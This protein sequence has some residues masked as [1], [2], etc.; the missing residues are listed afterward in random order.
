MSE[1][2]TLWPCVRH[3][4]QSPDC[5]LIDSCTFTLANVTAA[6]KQILNSVTN[7]IASQY[8]GYINL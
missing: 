6:T 3:I 2:P 5:L 1:I 8:D 7:F 4:Q